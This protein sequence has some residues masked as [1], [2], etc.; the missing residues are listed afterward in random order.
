[1]IKRIKTI[2]EFSAAHDILLTALIIV[3]TKMRYRNKILTAT[4]VFIFCLTALA[5]G[6]ERMV[7]GE[8]FTNFS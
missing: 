8:L 3:E 7:V 2:I 6:A 5:A 1:M 4:A